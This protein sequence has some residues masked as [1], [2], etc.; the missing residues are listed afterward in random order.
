[1][2]LAEFGREIADLRAALRS[3]I[4][5]LDQMARRATPGPALVRGGL[6]LAGLVAL[7]AG[8]PP[9]F[10][11]GRGAT[12]V[13][14]L[15]L[16]PVLLPRGVMPT[17]VI[18]LAALGWLAG[19][20]VYAQPVTYL[21]LVAVAGALYLLHTLAAL[22]AVLPYD[23]VVSAGVLG[24]WLLRA[25]LVVVLTAVL[26]L[27]AVAVPGLLG[28]GGYLLASLAGLGLLVGL[29]GYLASLVRRR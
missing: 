13:L 21:R 20:T 5:R 17:L 29:V 8:A 7:G 16:L 6:Y 9:G 1:V 27:A 12:F 26:G 2:T 28:A 19:T 10:V 14:V 11:L 18:V 15:A 24:R 3:R 4:E 23:A 25:A 22:A